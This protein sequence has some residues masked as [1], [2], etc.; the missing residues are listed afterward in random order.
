[1]AFFQLQS[2]GESTQ[3]KRIVSI[4][5]I[6]KQQKNQSVQAVSSARPLMSEQL[7]SDD[8]EKND[9]F[10]SVIDNDSDDDSDALEEIVNNVVNE[11]DNRDGQQVGGNQAE[12]EAN[13]EPMLCCFPQLPPEMWELDKV[14]NSLEEAKAYLENEGCWSFQTKYT[15]RQAYVTLYRCNKV[16]FKGEQC[17]AEVRVTYEIEMDISSDNESNEEQDA[18]EPH[19]AMQIAE[20]V[21]GTNQQ[22]EKNPQP[23]QNQEPQAAMPIAEPFAEG[24][25]DINKVGINV[26]KVFRKNRQHNHDELQL[27]KKKVKP[28]IAT[29]IIDLSK[30]YKPKSIVFELRDRGDIEEEEDMP[31]IRQV[32]NV[33]QNHKN[34]GYGSKPLTMRQLTEYVHENMAI[35]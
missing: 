4:A 32:R 24:A 34:M 19:D 27:A 33:L 12:N 31:S 11:I 6:L 20:I 1:M 25:Q 10:E 9:D 7:S 2:I 13:N 35:P 5:D 28:E 18:Q 23:E 29:L 21:E 14:F 17:G 22:Q 26:V 30:H 16:P 3:S 8:S 15:T